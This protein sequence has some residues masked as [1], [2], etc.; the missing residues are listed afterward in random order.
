MFCRRV[1]RWRETSNLIRKVIPNNSELAAGAYEPPP[2]D[3]EAID[4]IIQSNDKQTQ[5][6]N[7][8]T[9]LPSIR[10]PSTQH[11]ESRIDI[12]TDEKK[13]FYWLLR[14]TNA[15]VFA[16]TTLKKL[17][18]LPSEQS[19]NKVFDKTQIQWFCDRI[20]NRLL[21][22][23]LDNRIIVLQR[24]LAGWHHSGQ[25]HWH[26]LAK[27]ALRSCVINDEPLTARQLVKI[28]AALSNGDT[29]TSLRWSISSTLPP[30]PLRNG[31]LTTLL[32]FCG[33]LPI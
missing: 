18:Q 27:T 23:S 2:F 10:T 31:T 22:Y 8:Q 13:L 24:S 32:K 4:D 29:E 9:A 14:E 12:S 20:A 11:D 25:H 28:C 7:N 30:W 3:F 15:V 16:S 26:R 19:E 1:V 6:E 21:N 17:K 5:L 33:V